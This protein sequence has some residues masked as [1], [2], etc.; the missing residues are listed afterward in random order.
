M[1]VCKT[2]PLPGCSCRLDNRECCLSHLPWLIIRT[3]RICSLS[4]I[5][6]AVLWK[7]PVSAPCFLLQ[8][9][10]PSQAGCVFF[11][12]STL[13]W[14]AGWKSGSALCVHCFSR[15]CNFNSFCLFS[16]WCVPLGWV[17]SESLVKFI[18]LHS[19]HY[20]HFLPVL[21]LD[22]LGIWTPSIPMLWQG[23]GDAAAAMAA[24]FLFHEEHQAACLWSGQG[25]W[26]LGS[27][28]SRGQAGSVCLQPSWFLQPIPVGRFP[29]EVGIRTGKWLSS[30]FLA[31]FAAWRVYLHVTG[32][33]GGCTKGAV[34]VWVSAGALSLLVLGGSPVAFKIFTRSSLWILYYGD[35]FSVNA[36]R[37]PI[38]ELQISADAALPDLVPS[39]DSRFIWMFIRLLRETF[40]NT[41]FTSKYSFSR[42][43]MSLSVWI[44]LTAW[45]HAAVVPSC[46]TAGRSVAGPTYCA[47]L[48]PT[49]SRGALSSSPVTRWAVLVWSSILLLYFS[50]F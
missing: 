47:G 25:V 44:L 38:S 39:L 2:A 10:L 32:Q 21:F 11:Q 7:H 23:T 29:L 3:E 31:T 50:L 17:I 19:S 5:A 8:L 9:V 20:P 37:V 45:G 16:H 12:Q 28:S 4:R 30:G 14:G 34:S 13:Y 18:W 33:R 1:C 36:F 27:G 40:S 22:I 35:C 24:E 26:V 42:W 43:K 48:C 49:F 6:G 46:C 41:Q 15:F